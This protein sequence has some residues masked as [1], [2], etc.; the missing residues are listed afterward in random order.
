MDTNG[1][2]YLEILQQCDVWMCLKTGMLPP[3]DGKFNMEHGDKPGD[4]GVP[5]FQTNAFSKLMDNV[6][7]NLVA[8][9]NYDVGPVPW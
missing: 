3:I 4:L 1:D 6:Q 7:G 5:N 9:S 2:I 8:D